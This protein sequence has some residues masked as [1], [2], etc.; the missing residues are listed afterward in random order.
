MPYAEDRTGRV[1]SVRDRALNAV[2]YEAKRRWTSVVYAGWRTTKCTFDRR[3]QAISDKAAQRETTQGYVLNRLQLVK[4]SGMQECA[5][6]NWPKKFVCDRNGNGALPQRSCG[7]ASGDVKNLL[8]GNE[9]ADGVG[10]T[11]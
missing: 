8:A 4:D 5:D 1:T 11:A 9:R 3:G 6:T 7:N 10:R 2:S